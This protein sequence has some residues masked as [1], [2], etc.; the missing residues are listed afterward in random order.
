MRAS[1]LSNLNLSDFTLSTGLEEF[2]EPMVIEGDVAVAEAIQDLRRSQAEIAVIGEVRE[3]LTE[4]RTSMNEAKAGE[5]RARVLDAVTAGQLRVNPASVIADDSSYN[6]AA[7]VQY[8]DAGLESIPGMIMKGL[9]FLKELVKKGINLLLS[10][11]RSAKPVLSKHGMQLRKMK[12]VIVSNDAIHFDGQS[13]RMDRELSL[14]LF[15]SVVKGP[16][17]EITGDKVADHMQ[18]VE[19]GIRTIGAHLLG[20]LLSYTDNLA[21]GVIKHYGH[22]DA[23]QQKCCVNYDRM[24]VELRM[25][26]GRS[27]AIVPDYS[28]IGMLTLVGVP[29]SVLGVIPVNTPEQMVIDVGRSFVEVV[30]GVKVPPSSVTAPVGKDQAVLIIDRTINLLNSIDD[31]TDH[32][33]SAIQKTANATI[34]T[35][36]RTNQEAK[37][38]YVSNTILA[39]TSS[40]NMV[41]AVQSWRIKTVGAVSNAIQGYMRACVA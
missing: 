23:S 33:I 31:D 18:A 4:N 40:V 35:L 9:Q 32:D 41:L 12:E 30:G 11:M 16:A 20:G 14:G 26:R 38:D 25:E 17:R 34:N 7:A 24:P 6:G 1:T 27:F 10:Y 29:K 22:Y 15:S 37:A 8:V 28:G 3:Y 39:L 5:L 21:T 36:E 2:D 19:Y 13:V